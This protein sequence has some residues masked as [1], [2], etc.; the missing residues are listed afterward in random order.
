MSLFL[1]II[2]EF[3]KIQSQKK[4]KK[5]KKSMVAQRLTTTTKKCSSVFL[6]YFLV[7][8]PLRI[9]FGF[10][11]RIA[12]QPSNTR[13]C[14][15]LKLLLFKNKKLF[16]KTSHQKRDQNEPLVYLIVS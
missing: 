2:P 8:I 7:S 9:V 12:Q 15:C 14:Y 6:F 16:R 5:K 11:V 1:L 3:L 13:R 4:K 10:S